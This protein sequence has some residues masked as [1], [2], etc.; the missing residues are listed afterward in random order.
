[1]RAS[2]FAAFAL[3]LSASPALGAPIDAGVEPATVLAFQADAMTDA[4]LDFAAKS[5]TNALRQTVLD[6][7]E[8]TLGGQSPTLYAVAYDINCSLRVARG[9]PIDER[10]FD[11]ACLR[12]VGK[13][14]ETRRFFWGFLAVE[15][16]RPVVRLHLWQQGERDRV[17][18][19]P[20][21]P[22]ARDR[23]A[24]RLYRKLVTPEKVGDLA[25]V[26][27]AEGELVVDGKAAGP[28]APG[29]E[30]TL[31]AGEHAIEVR[32]GPRVVARAS[33]R[34][35]VRE[36]AEVQLKAV[37]EPVT[38]PPSRLPTEPP[39]VVIRPRPSAWPWVL[40]GTAGAGLAGAG[41]FWALHQRERNDL[42]RICR[43]HD[44]P[45]DQEGAADQINRYLTLSAISLGVGVA[46]GAGLATY[47]LAP[48]R[49]TPPV[50]GA[51][52]PIAG[53]MAASVAGSF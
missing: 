17:A 41:V 28:Y 52:I 25:L 14:L 34:V 13:H 1:M 46:A 48:G 7:P 21:D 35:A 29:V 38:A 39:P 26:G 9:R 22:S 12:K 40:G 47:L 19:L 16:G 11:E 2:R 5:L 44:C 4:E 32:Q 20:Y 24:E 51:I 10:T 27:A 15:G 6:S 45:P 36:R 49:R 37:A 30:L 53:G 18:S 8:Y 23:I 31:I 33:A 50:S 3:A 42:E 43:G